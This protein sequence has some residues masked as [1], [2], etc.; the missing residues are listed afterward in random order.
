MM[1]YFETIDL[2][3][4]LEDTVAAAVILLGAM[5]VWIVV[6]RSLLALELRAR[7]PEALL[8]PLKLLLRYGLI[9]VTMLLFLTAYGIPVGNFWTFVSTAVGLVAIGFVA[10]WS[11]LSNISST[12]LILI[13]RP[14]RLGDNIGIVGEEVA[15]RVTD[16][17]FLFTTIRKENGD[18]FKVPNN[19]FFQKTLLKSKDDPAQSGSGEGGLR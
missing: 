15:G 3:S 14:F 2:Y 1:T 11:V 17:N 18:L 13:A 6:A 19:Q 8:T 7:V 9:I 12:F 16:I 10:V 4:L 5:A